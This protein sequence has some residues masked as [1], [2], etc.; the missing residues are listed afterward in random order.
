MDN[1][2]LMPPPAT[3]QKPA[4]ATGTVALGAYNLVLDKYDDT[5]ME[6]KLTERELKTTRAE[7]KALRDAIKKGLYLKPRQ[8]WFRLALGCGGFLLIGWLLGRMPL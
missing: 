5:C 8:V 4:A 6:L 7:L 1:V 2:V 3:G